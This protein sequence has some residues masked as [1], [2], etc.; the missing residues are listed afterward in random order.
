MDSNNCIFRGQSVTNQRSVS[1]T[2][3]N[4]EIQINDVMVVTLSS[5]IYYSPSTE[6]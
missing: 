6:I 2:K 3:L 5:M 1:M 4:K